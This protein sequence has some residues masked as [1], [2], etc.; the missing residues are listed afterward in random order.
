MVHRHHCVRVAPSSKTPEGK[1]YE[2]Y[3]ANASSRG[4]E[5]HGVAMYNEFC[6]RLGKI[7]V[8]FIHDHDAGT[9]LQMKMENPFIKEGRDV[10]HK[11]KNV[12]TAIVKLGT[13]PQS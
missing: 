5:G 7:T 3:P 6:R 13:L 10:G 2:N 1:P 4:M 11:G 9:S 12:H 8:V